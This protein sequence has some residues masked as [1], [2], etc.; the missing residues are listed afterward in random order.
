MDEQVWRPREKELETERKKYQIIALFFLLE[1][2]LFTLGNPIKRRGPAL[3]IRDTAAIPPCG[4][5]ASDA[6]AVS[7]TGIIW[8]KREKVGRGTTF[9][10]SV[11]KLFS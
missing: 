1:D 10:I 7:T 6:T 9:Y 4:S 5:G 8:E 11:S 2:V 3:V